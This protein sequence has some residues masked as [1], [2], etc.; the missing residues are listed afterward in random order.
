VTETTRWTGNSF[1]SCPTSHMLRTDGR[2][3][4]LL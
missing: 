4:L 1:N 2:C 3:R